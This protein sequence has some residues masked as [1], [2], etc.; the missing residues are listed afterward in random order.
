MESSKNFLSFWSMGENNVGCIVLIIGG[1][2]LCF[3]GVQKS[4]TSFLGILGV[5][6]QKNSELELVIPF[7][8]H[9]LI[10]V[11]TK[12]VQFMTPKKAN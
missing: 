6:P 9:H 5:F 1:F 3:Y 2:Q 10:S 4:S 7:C 8:L 12:L 11:F